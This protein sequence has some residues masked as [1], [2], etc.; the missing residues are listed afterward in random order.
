M[1]PSNCQRH[2]RSTAS[3]KSS[4]RCAPAAIVERGHPAPTPIVGV[5]LLDEDIG[6]V[7]GVVQDIKQELAHTLDERGLLLGG[8]GIDARLARLGG[9]RLLFARRSTWRGN[10]ALCSGSALSLA[11]LR[12]TEGRHNDAKAILAPISDQFTE[13]FET[14][15]LRA[16]RDILNAPPS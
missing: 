4:R 9:G 15:D 8:N 16:A 12:V 6:R 10:R 11:R 13:G 3:A 5:D 14:A 7:E 1:V 2:E